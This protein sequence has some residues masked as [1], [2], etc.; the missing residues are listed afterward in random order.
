M[1]DSDTKRISRATYVWSHIAVIL[2]HIILGSI[3]IIT[4]FYDSIGKLKSKVIVFTVGIV[5][6]FMSFGSLV[7]ILMDN[8]KI[9]ID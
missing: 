5:L 8:K 9:E 3:L 6:V 7:P 2:F 4:Y 1:N